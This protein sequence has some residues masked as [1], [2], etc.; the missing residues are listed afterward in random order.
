[1][2]DPRFFEALGPATL[3]DLAEVA[4]AAPVDLGCLETLIQSA[5]TLNR[6]EAGSITFL[7]D[8]RYRTDLAA[9][10]ASACFVTAA[11]AE[12][13]PPGCAALVT[14]DPLTAYARVVERL[15][16]PRR[17][18]AC[19]VGVHPSAELEDGVVVAPGAVIGAEARIG[20][21]GYIGP[22][23]VIG[24]GVCIGRDCSIGAGV[25]IGFALIGDNV[26]IQAGAVIGEAGFGVAMGRGGALDVPQLG[27]VILQD[28][29]TVGSNSCIDRGMWDDTVIGE[30]TKIDNLVQIAHNVRLGRNC[31]VAAHT[32]ISGSTIIG[33]GV[34]LGGRVGIAD[35]ITVGDGARLMASAGVMHDIPAG[36]TWGGFPAVPARRWLRQVAWL[37]RMAH[38]RG[39]GGLN[40]KS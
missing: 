11:D 13:T 8:R 37:T 2:P 21:G 40:D 38:K 24:V 33:D 36:E 39:E 29:V 35:H 7:G 27:R 10:K 18:A 15:H 19:A 30:N 20:R 32:G 22:N 17:I 5:A 14:P 12:R 6:A 1:M 34:L 9:T 3:R 26:R 28:G 23:A 4:Q 31:A 16:R 25:S